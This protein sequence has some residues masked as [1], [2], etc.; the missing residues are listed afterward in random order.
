MCKHLTGMSSWYF[1]SCS[2]PISFFMGPMASKPLALTNREAERDRVGWHSREGTSTYKSWE[3]EEMGH[4]IWGTVFSY[5]GKD[6]G[7]VVVDSGL[8]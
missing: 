5:L 7:N 6:Y 4:I 3:W 1:P 8:Y 2:F